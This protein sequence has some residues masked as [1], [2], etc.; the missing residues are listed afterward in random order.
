M[1]SLLIGGNQFNKVEQASKGFAFEKKATNRPKTNTFYS[2][3]PKSQLEAEKQSIPLE[4]SYDIQVARTRTA[5][6]PIEQLSATY[7]NPVTKNP[8]GVFSSS[9]TPPSQKN[10]PYTAMDDTTY[11]RANQSTLPFL[12]P[13]F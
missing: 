9:C 3:E 2:P 13:P 12:L 5:Q 7:F 4:T 10:H 8:Y 6:K 11:M 1:K